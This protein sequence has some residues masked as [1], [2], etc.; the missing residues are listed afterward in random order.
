MRTIN[1][2]ASKTALFQ[3]L[4]ITSGVLAGAGCQSKKNLDA[5]VDRLVKAAI[6]NDYAEFKAMSAPALADQ[7]PPE[8]FA[9]FSKTLALLG[10]YTERTMKG[11]KVKTGGLQEGRYVLRFAKGKVD[12]ELKLQKGKLIAFYFTGDDL[13]RAMREARDRKFAEFKLAGFQWRDSGGKPASNIYKQGQSIHFLVEVWGLKLEDKSFN[14]KADLKVL[15]GEK[16]VLDQPA[17]VNKVLPLSEGQPPLA[18]LN[19]NLN[20]PEAGNYKLVLAV[21]DKNTQKVTSHEE[22]FVVEAAK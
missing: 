11:I 6:K 21:T 8:K 22:A 3:A 2:T 14:L 12:L 13:T 18:S 10:D 4:L 20:I 17:F 19:G 9:E 16:L 1:V 15:S 5:S 7:F